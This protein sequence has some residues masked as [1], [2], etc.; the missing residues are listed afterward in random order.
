MRKLVLSIALLVVGQV[1]LAQGLLSADYH[2]HRESLQN[3]F[4]KFQNEKKGRVALFGW[5]HNF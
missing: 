5:L 1:L 3:S 4:L 2:T